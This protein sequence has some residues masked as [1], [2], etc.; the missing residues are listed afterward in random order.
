M[1]RV[2]SKGAT[3]LSD[4]TPFVLIDVTRMDRNI[5]E[6]AEIAGRNVVSLR[7]H[8]KTHKI[9]AIARKQ[10]E[11]GATGITVAKSS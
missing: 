2:V 11:V 7:P 10:V 6:M 1:L 9:P 4:H 3:S 5:L 8:V